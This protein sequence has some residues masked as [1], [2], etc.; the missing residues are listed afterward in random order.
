MKKRTY[1]DSSVLIAAYRGDDRI[2]KEALTILEDQ[3]R[4]IVVSDYVRLE[5]LPKPK[6][7]GYTGEVVFMQAVFAKGQNV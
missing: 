7:L 6:Y 3:Q 5:V 4:E 2:A 1:V